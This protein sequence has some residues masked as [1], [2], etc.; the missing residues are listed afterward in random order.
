MTTVKLDNL[1]LM[2]TRLLFTLMDMVILLLVIS[3]DNTIRIIIKS[4]QW[5]KDREI[6]LD[7][8]IM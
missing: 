4:I 3:S 7:S 8:F 2:V 6:Q 1:F 5:D